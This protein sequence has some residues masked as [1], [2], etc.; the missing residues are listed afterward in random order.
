MNR[1][2]LI[3]SLFLAASLAAAED[4]PAAPAPAPAQP[5][6]APEPP[7]VALKYDELVLVDG[8]QLKKVTIK[9]Y[10]AKSEKLLMI[11]NGKAMSL[12]IAQVPAP[13]A[14]QLKAGAP[15]AGASLSTA[16]APVPGPV[17]LTPHPFENLP[18]TQP[19][20]PVTQP[21]QAESTDAHK[22]A[23]LSRARNYYRSEFALG[24]DAA[25]VTASNFEVEEPVAVSGW[26]G[27]YRTEGKVFLEWF[28]SKGWSYKRGTSTFEV[29]T[30]KSTGS[31]PKV[32]S[33]TV[34]S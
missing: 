26:T 14:E 19:V 13:L 23:A 16:P 33:F 24:S 17:R 25:R 18:R 1:P 5:A 28:D 20:A 27:R 31:T 15:Q 30:E 11:A 10:D 9:S 4:K 32:V 6:A 22:A 34:K 29:L 8:S 2:L 3:L 12:P 7:P 21:V